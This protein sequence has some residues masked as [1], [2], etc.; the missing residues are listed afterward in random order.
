MKNTV[1]VAEMFDKTAKIINALY[2][3]KEGWWRDFD[4]TNTTPW[5]PIPVNVYELLGY[6]SMSIVDILW[7]QH[8]ISLDEITI[9]FIVKP[10]VAKSD[11]DGFWQYYKTPKSPIIDRFNLAEWFN[12]YYPLGEALK[13]L[14]MEFRS[15]GTYARYAINSS[16]TAW[17]LPVNNSWGYTGETCL[18]EKRIA[19]CPHDYDIAVNGETIDDYKTLGDNNPTIV[20]DDIVDYEECIDNFDKHFWD[21]EYNNWQED[22]YKNIDLED[23]LFD[24]LDKVFERIGCKIAFT[25]TLLTLLNRKLWEDTPNMVYPA[26]YNNE[27]MLIIAPNQYDYSYIMLDEFINSPY[28]YQ[29]PTK[30]ATSFRITPTLKGILNPIKQD[31]INDNPKD[32]NEDDE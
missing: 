31:N 21:F 9:E 32:E 1:T 12:R 16:D 2:N 10:K 17:K 22:L 11:Y 15:V 8:E 28:Y 7:R 25:D 4:E 3:L 30:D 23:V 5:Q 27:P 6:E 29:I 18:D 26:R 20:P 24:T 19:I 13:V 14:C